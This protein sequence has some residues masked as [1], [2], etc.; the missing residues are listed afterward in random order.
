MFYTFVLFCR[1][2][3]RVN[4]HTHNPCKY[5]KNISILQINVG[6]VRSIVWVREGKMGTMGMLGNV[7]IMGIMGT[8]GRVGRIFANLSIP[9]LK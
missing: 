9:F 3:T 2:C 7:G 6:F 1:M 5:R 4:T 8:M